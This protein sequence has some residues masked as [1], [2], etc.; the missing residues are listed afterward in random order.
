M[1]KVNLWELITSCA[2]KDNPNLDNCRAIK[3]AAGQH[4][5]FGNELQLEIT[6]NGDWIIRVFTCNP[7]CTDKVK[8]SILSCGHT[9]IIRDRTRN[10]IAELRSISF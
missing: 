10:G 1:A 2:Q 4:P 3:N 9:V 5:G 7:D 8:L 6:E